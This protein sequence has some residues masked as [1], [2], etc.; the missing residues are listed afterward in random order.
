MSKTRA[1]DVL[2]GDIPV[3]RLALDAG[4]QAS[5]SFF[6]RYRR[7][8]PRPVLGQMFEDDLYGRYVGKGRL[9]VWFSNLL[10][11][12][13]LRERAQ[14]ALGRKERHELYLLARL[15]DDLPGAVRMLPAGEDVDPDA[16]VV[17]AAEE[18]ARAAEEQVRF[19]LAGVQDKFPVLLR[20]D[21]TFFRPL[22]GVG[23]T[24]IAKLPD[25]N[26]AG[27]PV[28]EHAMMTWAKLAGLDVPEVAMAS[29]I[30]RVD[31]ARFLR[32][33][34]AF[35]VRRFDRAS[36]A[37]R[38]HIEDMA[39]VFGQYPAEKYDSRTYE[40]LGRLIFAVAG[41]VGL[42]ELVRRLVFV[43]AS[44]NHDMHLKNW[45]LLYPDGV[46]AQLAP[47]YDLLA[48]VAYPDVSDELALKLA[49]TKRWATTRLS[50]FE[51]FARDV[52]ADVEHVKQVIE[53]TVD[54]LVA[55]RAEA[56]ARTQLPGEVWERINAHWKRVPLLRN[57]AT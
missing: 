51:S 15:A 40:D 23:G 41:P 6:E 14:A 37:G 56:R 57:R 33:E 30:E 46:S 42:D 12:G 7:Q 3:G 18:K 32:G 4:G 8:Y 5:F 27:V 10:P 13:L 53:Q 24:W 29:A 28:N 20:D 38:L 11:E 25:A 44:G 49:G 34:R 31:G 21:G 50:S 26:H 36:G 54:A 22:G 55:S 16:E 35:V 43:I 47:A 39:Q 1:L 2:L 52:G 9:P 48:T 19:S 45:S 17:Y